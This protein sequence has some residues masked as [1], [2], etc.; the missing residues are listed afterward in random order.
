M[1]DGVEGETAFTSGTVSSTHDIFTTAGGAA[2][3]DVADKE[4]SK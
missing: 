4:N 1:N 3:V 2:V